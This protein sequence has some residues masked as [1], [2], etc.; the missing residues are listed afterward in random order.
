MI[1]LPTGC[2]SRGLGV[3]KTWG[4]DVTTHYSAPEIGRL[5]AAATRI[6]VGSHET[7]TPT[8]RG[9]AQR[10]PKSMVEREGIEPSTP[11]L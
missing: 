4:P 7:S 9:M 6:L 11:A 3:V 1:E 8:L 2:Y 5:M 10:E